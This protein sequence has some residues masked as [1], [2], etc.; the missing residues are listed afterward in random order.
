MAQLS[1]SRKVALSLVSQRRRH[2]GRIRELLRTSE[3]MDALEDARDRALAAR[4]AFGAVSAQ[5]TLDRLLDERLRR[6]SSVE[7]RVRDALRVAAFECCYLSTPQS[8]AV[9][10]GVELVRLASP[11]AAGLANAVLR[12]LCQDVRPQVQD[13]RARCA[14]G[15]CG[16][17]DLALVGGLPSWLLERVAVQRGLDAARN[18]ALCQL[19]AAPVYVAANPALAT[20]SETLRSLREA[21]L[22]PQPTLLP[23]AFQL[24]APAG[25]AGSGL[26]GSGQLAV[27][28]LAAQL[29][30]CMASPQP[31]YN[32]LEV[33][34]GRGT[35]TMLLQ[36]EA[37]AQGGFC[38][39]TGVDSEA[40]KT[41][42][43]SRRMSRAG[44]AKHVRCVTLDGRL[45]SSTTLPGMPH[46]GFDVAFV[47]A[48]CSGTGTMRRHPEIAWTL[49]A[50]SL[51]GEGSLPRLQLQLLAAA[52]ACV[53]TGGLLAYAT[54]SLMAEENERVVESFLESPE[55]SRFEV[56]PAYATPGVAMASEGAQEA[57]RMRTDGRGWF[58]SIPAT[59]SFDGHF[60][61]V[62]RRR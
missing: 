21:G 14:D 48:P 25:L 53:R 57:V 38:E 15:A 47:D 17:D 24:G 31:G 34:Q 37:L 1:P 9:S 49:S 54:C 39:V 59:A 28:D 12:R 11:R 62:M 23:R 51:E 46:D 26:V 35:K 60:C 55:G 45:V 3:A 10:Q 56:V 6:P 29:V 27:S 50:E 41:K 43:T 13:A 58:Q 8:A 19:E 36:G 18:L 61:T 42:V 16:I 30:A 4:L 44:L 22:D 40:F 33:G 7:P 20:T 32:V 2:D 5:G 52:S